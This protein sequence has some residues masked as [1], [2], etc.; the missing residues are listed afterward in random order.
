MSSF[1]KTDTILDQILA[2]KVEQ[3]AGQRA[4]MR[5]EL[6]IEALLIDAAGNADPALDF[7]G[8]LR[9]IAARGKMALIAEVKKASPSKGVLMEKFDPEALATTY[10][11]NGAAAISVLTDEPFF[12]GSL[13]HLEIVREA[14]AIPILRKEFVIDPIQIYEARE[15]GADAVLLI[16]MALTDTQLNNLYGLITGLGMD[17]LIEVHNEAELERALAIGATLIGVNNRDLRTFQEDLNTTARVAARV[18]TNVTLVAESAIRTPDDVRRMG[19]LGA[20]AVLVGEG[21]VKAGNI[22]AQVRQFS[23]QPRGTRTP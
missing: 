6:Y 10:A 22:A 23:T 19:D 4:E 8:T 20:H 5:E 16:V 15:A 9:K 2:R 11:D 7:A 3:I 14:V 12:Q 1:V 18:P 17:A 13:E 21:L